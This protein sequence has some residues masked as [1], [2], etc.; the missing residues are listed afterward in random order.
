MPKKRSVK[1]HLVT[2]PSD[3]SYRLIP[4]TRGKN[5]IVDAEDFEW[6]SKWNWCTALTGRGPLFSFYAARS[7]WT[8]KGS[9]FLFMHNVIFGDRC[10]HKNRNG[11]DN[12][13]EN[14]RACTPLQNSRN[15][16]ISKNNISGFKGVSFIASIN[17]WR[18]RITANGKSKFLGYFTSKELAACAYDLAAKKLFGEF[19]APNFSTIGQCQR[20]ISLD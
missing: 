2:Q 3:S 20:T 18:A 1:R 7:Y 16:G 6:L 9:R 12:R 13:R 4:L 15:R 14:L 10:D 8:K 17:K 11:L 19:A 5:A